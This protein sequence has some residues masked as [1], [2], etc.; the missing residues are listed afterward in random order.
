MVKIESL[1]LWF[2]SSAVNYH[3]SRFIKSN[4]IT[5]FSVF[6][7]HTP[8]L[9]TMMTMDNINYNMIWY[10]NLLII[11]LPSNFVC[12]NIW[13]RKLLKTVKWQKVFNNQFKYISIVIRGIQRIHNEIIFDYDGFDV[14]I[15]A[16]VFVIQ[17]VIHV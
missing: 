12:M 11:S 8:F 15:R 3:L 7:A 17:I 10:Y 14:V 16:Y 1:L 6:K 4:A 9:I 2:N 13:T 5:L